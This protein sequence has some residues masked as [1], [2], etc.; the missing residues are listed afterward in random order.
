MTCIVGLVDG[1][2][3]YIGGDSAGVS[4]L[5]LQVRA[6]AKVFKKDWMVFGFT[7]SFR[8]GQLLRYSL[9]IPQ[10]HPDTDVMKWMC[11]DFIDA[12]RNC[13]KSGGFAKKDSE[14]ESGGAFLVGY[15]GR[16]FAVHGDYQVAETAAPYASVGCG[17]AYAVGAMYASTNEPSERVKLALECAAAN[18]AGVRG[19]FVIESI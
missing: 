18:S 5:D 7:S 6:D 9:S 13:L 16:L 1:G 2:R 11:S 3:V 14:V 10:R 12:V 17:E 4:G 15:A 8:M 19:P